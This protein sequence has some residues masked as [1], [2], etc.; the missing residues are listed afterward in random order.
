MYQA[1]AGDYLVQKIGS[2]YYVFN[3]QG[4]RLTNSTIY[5][6]GEKWTTDPTGAEEGKTKIYTINSSGVAKEGT[7][8]K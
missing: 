3:D 7:Y 4:N 5:K 1:S 2:R 6:I 8:K